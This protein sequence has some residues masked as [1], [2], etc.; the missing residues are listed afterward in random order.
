MDLNISQ[1]HEE[2]DANH[3]EKL[4][5]F[6][7]CTVYG[8]IHQHNKRYNLIRRLHFEILLIEFRD[9]QQSPP[10]WENYFGHLGLCKYFPHSYISYFLG[11]YFIYF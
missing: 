11:G 7:L 8:H 5:R 10:I 4:G 6:A 9:C 2:R 1:R 3:W